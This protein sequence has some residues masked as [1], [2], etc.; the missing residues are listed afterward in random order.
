MDIGCMGI[1][2]AA[3]F[4]KLHQIKSYPSANAYRTDIRDLYIPFYHNIEYMSSELEIVDIDETGRILIPHRLC[5]M[6]G[7]HPHDK[8]IIGVQNNTLLLT[9]QKISV[10]DLQKKE[11]APGTLKKSLIFE[12]EIDAAGKN[13]MPVQ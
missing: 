9:K 6:I 7:I 13:D 10:F 5:E 12:R 4:N 11:V 2:C 8:L 3:I 1:S